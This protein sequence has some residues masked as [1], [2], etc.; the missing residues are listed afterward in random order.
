MRKQPVHSCEYCANNGMGTMGRWN[1]S[2]PIYG[3]VYL[4][5][6]V[7]NVGQLSWTGYIRYMHVQVMYLDR[8]THA[9]KGLDLIRGIESGDAPVNAQRMNNSRAFLTSHGEK[10]S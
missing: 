10:A 4:M 8:H 2:N 3:T 1:S 6:D 5:R 7:L 9:G